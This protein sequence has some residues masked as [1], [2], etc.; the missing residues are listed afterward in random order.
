MHRRGDTAAR[1]QTAKSSMDLQFALR[2]GNTPNDFVKQVVLEDDIVGAGSD[3]PAEVAAIA[4]CYRQTIK[5]INE[6]LTT[7]S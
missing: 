1:L 7:L 2:N 3:D 4:A 6:Q 5:T